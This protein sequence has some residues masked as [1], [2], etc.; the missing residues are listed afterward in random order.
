MPWATCAG[1]APTA[2]PPARC[3]ANPRR[4][5]CGQATPQAAWLLPPHT[6]SALVPECERAAHCEQVQPGK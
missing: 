6:S 1:E 5:A 2:S 4:T 3:R